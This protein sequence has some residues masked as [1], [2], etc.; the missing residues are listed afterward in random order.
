MSKFL[1]EEMNHCPYKTAKGVKMV[2]L[3]NIRGKPC[4]RHLMKRLKIQK[5]LCIKFNML[6]QP[7]FPAKTHPCVLQVISQKRSGKL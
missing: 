7:N 3:Y 6:Y 4:K 2:R 5:V 1:L